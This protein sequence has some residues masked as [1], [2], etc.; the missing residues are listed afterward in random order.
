MRGNWMNLG[1]PADRGD[2]DRLLDG[3]RAGTPSADEPLARLL[4]DAAGPPRP[5]DLAG[6][7]DA[8]TAFRAAR[9]APDPRPRRRASGLRPLAWIAGFAATATAG[10]AFAAVAVD[11]GD[12]PPPPPAPVGTTS[13]PSPSGPATGRPTEPTPMQTPASTDRPGSPTAATTPARPTDEPD[14]GASDPAPT[15]SAA[16]GA[17]LHGHCNAYLSKKP[18]QREKALTKPGF[19]GLVTA[20]GGADRVE[21]YCRALDP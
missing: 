12:P 4:A 3:A 18:Q 16:A 19:A 7:Q 17:N 2:L 5:G 9:S 6:E 14:A 10:V 15:P 1:R 11:D 20:A 13:A 8:L 21:E